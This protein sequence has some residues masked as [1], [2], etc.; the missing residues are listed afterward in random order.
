MS[1]PSVMTK[2]SNETLGWG[3][4][5]V[6]RDVTLDVNTGE[7]IALLGRSGTGKSTLLGALRER[8]ET[9]THRAALVPQDLGLVPQLSVFHNVYMGRLDDY[10]T[11][12]NLG[13][14][15]YPRA[16]D[17][18]EIG[19]I[20]ASVGLND[21]QR[22]SAETLSGGQRQRVAIARALYRGGEIVFADEPVSAVDVTQGHRLI[23]HLHQSFSTS[24]MALH[25]VDLA[26][27]HA[28]RVIGLRGGKVA[29]DLAATD[30][31][32]KQVQELYA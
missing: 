12:R 20:L 9:T 5:P 1:A 17:R 15:I 24:I 13:T 8:I 29:F 4:A 14:L 26:R 30:L 16:S 10:G 23:E 25:N 31:T 27:A 18:A 3:D 32:D 2:L 21:M 6:L 11:L 22:K 7:R 19:A 28:T